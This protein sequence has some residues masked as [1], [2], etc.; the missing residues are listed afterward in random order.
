MKTFKLIIGILFL[1]MLGY[2]ANAQSIAEQNRDKEYIMSIVKGAN[3]VIIHPEKTK[4]KYGDSETFYYTMRIV[5]KKSTYDVEVQMYYL[6]GKLA[7]VW[8]MKN[9]YDIYVN[10]FK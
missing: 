3:K 5:S 1:L 8:V 6:K 10:E 2:T 7:G 9:G 4:M